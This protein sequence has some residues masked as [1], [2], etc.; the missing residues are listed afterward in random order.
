MGTSYTMQHVNFELARIAKAIIDSHL[1]ETRHRLIIGPLPWHERIEDSGEFHDATDDGV[2][3]H[4]LDHIVPGPQGQQTPAAGAARRPFNGRRR[5]DPLVRRRS[6]TGSSRRC[7]GDPCRIFC[8]NRTITHGRDKN[9]EF[10]LAWPSLGLPC[11]DPRS[12]TRCCTA[13]ASITSS[14]DPAEQAEF[15]ICDLII[16]RIPP[17][18]S[19]SAAASADLR[20]LRADQF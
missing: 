10:V 13:T 5:S 2:T 8:A 11:G 16:K 1:K 3:E 6:W 14:M 18:G 9:V 19:R 17:S 20:A 15:E 12:E 4:M 7:G